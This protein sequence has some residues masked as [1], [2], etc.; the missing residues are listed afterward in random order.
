MEGLETE[1]SHADAGREE[2]TAFITQQRPVVCEEEVQHEEAVVAYGRDTFAHPSP[3]RDQRTAGRFGV[4]QTL[5][6][7]ATAPSSVACGPD[8]KLRLK[9][10]AKSQPRL[11]TVKAPRAEYLRCRLAALEAES[12]KPKLSTATEPNHSSKPPSFKR[13]IPGSFSSFHTA[14]KDALLHVHWNAIMQG[15]ALKPI[16]I[17]RLP[18]FLKWQADKDIVDGQI[19]VNRDQDNLLK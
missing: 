14:L 15:L 2:S 17:V 8:E 9:I 7:V 10:G 13:F 1:L 3:A 16:D 12:K 5:K 6:S 19:V 18:S 4:T 11:L